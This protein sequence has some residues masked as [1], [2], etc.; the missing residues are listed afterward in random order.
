MRAGSRVAWESARSVRWGEEAVSS[1]MGRSLNEELA[2]W[3]GKV[4]RWA[5]AHPP[6]RPLDAVR[7]PRLQHHDLG[8]LHV[9]LELLGVLLDR[10]E[11]V[12]VAWDHLLS[13]DQLGRGH[14]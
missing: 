3:P 10:R 7:L 13:A 11:G 2:G 5:S 14:A 1:I 12:V 9:V 4:R 6:T 8:A